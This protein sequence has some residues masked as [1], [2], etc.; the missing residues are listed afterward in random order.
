MVVIIL[1]NN[2]SA[3]AQV[4]G[5]FDF[6]RTP[7]APPGIKVLVHEKPENRNTWAPH[8]VEGW[9]VGPAMQSY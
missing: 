6:N 3:W 9:Y 5:Q 2:L 7:I 1:F 4:H 8:A